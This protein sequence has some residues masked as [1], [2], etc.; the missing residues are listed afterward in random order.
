MRTLA[1]RKHAF[2]GPVGLFDSSASTGSW[3][4]SFLPPKFPPTMVA[5]MRTRF[6]GS[7][8]VRETSARPSVMRPRLLRMVT[9]PLGSHTAI[10]ACG[11][12][13]TCS[14][15]WVVYRPSKM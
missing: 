3:V 8:K 1:T 6:I 15:I 7:F 14:T 13:G 10:A 4:I 5:T 9:R 12:R 2:D 11:S